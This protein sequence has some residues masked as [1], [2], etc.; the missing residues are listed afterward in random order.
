M[1]F[2]TLQREN[3]AKDIICSL[4]EIRRFGDVADTDITASYFRKRFII[5][6]VNIL[7]IKFKFRK[8]N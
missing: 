6:Q 3:H 2:I 8:K 5:T 1:N 7:L 4:L